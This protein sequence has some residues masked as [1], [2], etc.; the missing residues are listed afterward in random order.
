MVVQFFPSLVAFAMNIS[1]CT[2]K[3]CLMQGEN[4]LVG[5]VMLPNMGSLIVCNL[6][7]KE[8][9]CCSGSD[10]MVLH[11]RFTVSSNDH[12]I[13]KHPSLPLLQNPQNPLAIHHALNGV[14]FS[15]LQL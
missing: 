8:S 6:Q 9:N 7:R 10:A 15:E 5:E 14:L 1:L 11:T 3:T 12:Q 4:E 13:S 2:K